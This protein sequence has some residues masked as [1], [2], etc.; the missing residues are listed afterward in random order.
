MA[1]GAAAPLAGAEPAP[2]ASQ[3]VQPVQPAQMMLAQEYRGQAVA[4]WLMS[5]KLDGVRAFWDGRQLIGRSGKAFTAPAWFTQGFPPFALDGELFAGR[6][7]FELAAAAVHSSDPQAW[8]PLHYAVFDVPN[9]AGGLLQR[10][11]VLRDYLAQGAAAGA[12]GAAPE[13]IRIVQQR[14]V[15]DAA[16]A[17]AFLREIEAGGGEGVM[18]RH[19]QAAYPRGRSEL[20]LKMKSAHDAECVVVA[21]HP[22]RGRLQGLLGSLS[23]E[24][25]QGRFRIGSGFSDRER[26]DPPPIGSTITYR[27][28]GLTAKGLPRFASFVRIRPAQGD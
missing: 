26:S 20:L 3:P 25:A 13:R 19:P 9:A 12:A 16:A 7:R 22:G 24:N 18:L 2:Q 28:R 10:L 6:G 21:H 11:Q 27:Y 8:Q 15:A 23:C 14:P 17:Q 1:L 5:E 4:G